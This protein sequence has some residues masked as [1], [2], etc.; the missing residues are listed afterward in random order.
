MAPEI[1]NVFVKVFVLDLDV[2][3]SVMCGE[4]LGNGYPQRF[5]L[6]SVLLLSQLNKAQ[7]IA[8]YF[9]GV[10]VTP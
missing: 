5:E 7:P 2:V 9:T 8:E 10:L 3:A 6:L 1:A 4:P